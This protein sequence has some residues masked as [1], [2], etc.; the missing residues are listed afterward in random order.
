MVTMGADDYLI[1]PFA[2]MELV[3][4]VGAIFLD[5]NF[6]IT[7]NSEELYLSNIK[8]KIL[9]LKNTFNGETLDVT[10]TEFIHC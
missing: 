2:P 6:K 8:L 7:T 4:R 1:K 9:P 5:M 10:P 3:V